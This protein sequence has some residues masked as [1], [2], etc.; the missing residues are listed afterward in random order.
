MRPEW[1]CGGNGTLETA[2]PRANAFPVETA[3]AA[4]IS[5]SDEGTGDAAGKRK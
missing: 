5:G 2:P 3:H 4:K 1:L